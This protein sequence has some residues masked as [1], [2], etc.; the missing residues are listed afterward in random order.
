MDHIQF[1]NL[2]EG[3]VTPSGCGFPL[4]YIVFENVIKKTIKY[5]M[6]KFSYC[7]FTV[8]DERNRITVLRIKFCTK[9]RRSMCIIS[10]D[11]L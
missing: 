5:K 9:C 3:H 4:N 6:L 11:V 7:I 2:S 1:G 10:P 8:H